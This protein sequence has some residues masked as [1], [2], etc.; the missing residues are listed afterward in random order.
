MSPDS[1]AHHYWGLP[2]SFRGRS[3]GPPENPDEVGTV[4]TS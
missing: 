2:M 4:D 1:F 3:L